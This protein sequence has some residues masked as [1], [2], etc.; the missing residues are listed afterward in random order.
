MRIEKEQARINKMRNEAGPKINPLVCESSKTQQVAFLAWKREHDQRLE[1]GRLRMLSKQS[2]VSAGTSTSERGRL[3]NEKRKDSKTSQR[4]DSK[5]IVDDD[6]N[7][8]KA[9]GPVHLFPSVEVAGAAA[10]LFTTSMSSNVGASFQAFGGERRQSSPVVG[11]FG[12][13]RGGPRG[14]RTKSKAAT[15]AELGG[16]LVPFRLR[17]KKEY[18][19]RTAK[20]EKLVRKYHQRHQLGEL[21]RHG[22]YDAGAPAADIGFNPVTDGPSSTAAQGRLEIERQLVS[23]LVDD[24]DKEDVVIEGS[25]ALSG[26]GTS[27]RLSAAGSK[28][29]SLRASKPLGDGSSKAL[30][31]VGFLDTSAALMSRELASGARRRKGGGFAP[32]HAMESTERGGVASR[33]T[34][35]KP[36][37]S[38]QPRSSIRQ[39]GGT[40][41]ASKRAPSKNS[42]RASSKNSARSQGSGKISELEEQKWTNLRGHQARRST[43]LVDGGIAAEHIDFLNLKPRMVNQIMK[44]SWG[45]G[46]AESETCSSASSSAV[47]TSTSFYTSRKMIG[48]GSAPIQIGVGPRDTVQ[49]QAPLCDESFTMGDLGVVATVSREDYTTRKAASKEVSTASK[50]AESHTTR[51]RD[52]SARFKPP[53]SPVA[54]PRPCSRD[55]RNETPPADSFR[56]RSTGTSPRVEFVERRR[57]QMLQHMDDCW[58]QKWGEQFPD[59]RAEN[60]VSKANDVTRKSLSGAP[61]GGADDSPIVSVDLPMEQMGRGRRGSRGSKTAGRIKARSAPSSPSGRF[62]TAV[63]MV[64]DVAWGGMKIVANPVGRKLSPG[65]IPIAIAGDDNVYHARLK[66]IYEGRG[67]NSRVE[68]EMCVNKLFPHAWMS[69]VVRHVRH[70]LV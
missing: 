33:T 5:T 31:S 16:L 26:G 1:E 6:A 17:R 46:G 13:P 2:A 63:G 34:E 43:I 57:L 56:P 45:E 67:K 51:R 47:D 50:E 18:D 23:T 10:E 14:A 59:G 24:D 39:E 53:G 11:G 68:E 20:Q 30:R 22:I 4:Q 65:F 35:Q 7:M 36:S 54:A 70:I 29:L 48:G 58:V 28:R 8:L 3:L 12:G 52:V 62:P 60:V 61:S 27:R 32:P 37:P 49:E 9:R 40:D 15:A 55:H 21:S 42:A 66:R 44:K 19:P 25:K 64:N 41:T 69:P 38:E